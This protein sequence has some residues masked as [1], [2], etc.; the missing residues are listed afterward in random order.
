MPTPR[1]TATS[2]G[3]TFPN[4]SGAAAHGTIDDWVRSLSAAGKTANLVSAGF[5]A[6]GFVYDGV[7]RSATF[8]P[9]QYL[10]TN[11]AKSKVTVTAAAK[12][13]TVKKGNKVVIKGKATPVGPGAK[14]TLEVK[15]KD[16]TWKT[17]Q[18][19]DLAASGDFKLQAKAGK[20][21]KAKYRVTVS[22]TNSTAAATS[23]KVKVQIVKK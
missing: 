15:K 17:V 1:R 13:A 23:N 12:H 8:G 20:T 22:E 9:N 5:V 18:T 3:C 10:F 14:V 4:G 21:G 7:L 16:G 2:D 11:S 6:T 19:K